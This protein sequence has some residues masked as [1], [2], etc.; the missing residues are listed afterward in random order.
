MAGFQVPLSGRFWV[1]HDN[2]E[3]SASST[4]APIDVPA[5]INWLLSSNGN[6]W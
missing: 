5:L 2:E 1:P 3:S 4:F 6:I